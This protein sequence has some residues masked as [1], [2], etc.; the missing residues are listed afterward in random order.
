MLAA[1]AEATTASG[2]AKPTEGLFPAISRWH[3]PLKLCFS[4]VSDNHSQVSRASLRIR[5]LDVNDNPPELAIPYEASVCEDAKPGQVSG[6]P[7]VSFSARGGPMAPAVLWTSASLPRLHL[8]Q[9]LC[10]CCHA[11]NRFAG[12]LSLSW[13]AGAEACP[14]L[15]QE[16]MML[17][18]FGPCEP[19][20]RE[21]LQRWFQFSSLLSPH[22]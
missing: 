12:V 16:P 8:C 4:F 10:C 9:S 5:I 13:P 2:Q 6:T 18:W 11:G 22:S 21:G 1:A 20:P 15:R 14:W 3:F 17:R 19:G 7:Q